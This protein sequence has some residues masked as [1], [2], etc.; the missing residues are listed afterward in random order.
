ME[1][2]FEDQE[3]KGIPTLFRQAFDTE[4][5]KHFHYADG[6]GN[7]LKEIRK[8]IKN[9][10][11][12]VGVF[13]E[14]VI[15]NEYTWITLDKLSNSIHEQKALQNNVVI[16]PIPCIEYYYIKYLSIYEPHLVVHA[17]SIETCL[18]FESYSDDHLL[19]QTGR[20]DKCT[21]HERFCKLVVKY[22]FHKC[23]RDEN[24][25]DSTFLAADCLCSSPILGCKQSTVL[26]KAIQMVSLM[27]VIPCGSLVSD[28]L[29]NGISFDE[30]LNLSNRMIDAVRKRSREFERK[31]SAKEAN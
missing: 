9:G 29:L 21:T 8:C 15:D 25:K 5:A 6:A 19:E 30:A 2:I 12:K 20:K 31:V 1:Y 26:D 4:A 28:K 22:A 14:L 17:D 18:K 24:S 10:A 13:L 16:I 27:E 3:N 23:V 11:D 7:L